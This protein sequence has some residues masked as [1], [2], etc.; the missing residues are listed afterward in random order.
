MRNAPWLNF[1]PAH[2]STG[3]EP[4][5]IVVGIFS[6]DASMLRLITDVLAGQHN[7]WGVARPYMGVESL[8]R[9]RMRVLE[10]TEMGVPLARLADVAQNDNRRSMQRSSHTTLLGVAQDTRSLSGLD[11]DLVGVVPVS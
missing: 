10:G 1:Y 8:Q 4:R 3:I 5:S 6:N 9:G 7:E 2:V 11:R